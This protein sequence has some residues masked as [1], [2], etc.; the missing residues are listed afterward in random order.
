MIRGGFAF[1]GCLLGAI[2]IGG[3]TIAR[4]RLGADGIGG[5]AG[6]GC[7]NAGEGLASIFEING[8]GIAARAPL[9]GRIRARARARRVCAASAQRQG[10]AFWP[11]ASSPKFAH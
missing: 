3:V 5:G 8:D 6:K 9:S 2:R 4:R 10:A 11:C 7:F 1:S